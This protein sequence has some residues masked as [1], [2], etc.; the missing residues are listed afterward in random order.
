L[1][2]FSYIRGTMRIIVG[3]TNEV[4]IGAVRE[5]APE[6]P[7]IAGAAISGI[8]VPSD[9]SSQPK[10]LEETMT[11]AMNRARGA[12]ERGGL[13][14][15]DG[16]LSFGIESGL[17]AVPFTRTGHMDVCVC[18]I[19]DG[20]EFDFGLSSAWESP[21][22][23]TKYMVEDGLDMNQAY[24]KAGYIDDPKI[25]SSL[26]AIGLVTKGRLP[27]IKYTVESVR[28]AL[29]GVEARKQ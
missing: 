15:A 12:W 6:Y 19:F 24:Q 4:K 18:A 28:T 10:S 20:N 21:A 5:L 25:G 22:I 2:S 3:T 13:N 23:V 9:V 8:D 1:V 17:F 11:G 16:D 26:G 29:I 27:R 14:A 7:C